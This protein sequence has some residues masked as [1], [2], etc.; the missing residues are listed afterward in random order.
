MIFINPLP[1]TY[2]FGRTLTPRSQKV[3]PPFL[4][5]LK[6]GLN[7]IFHLRTCCSKKLSV[8]GRAPPTKTMSQGGPRGGMC[9]PLYGGLKGA[10][11]PSHPSEI[12]GV[13]GCENG[14]KMTLKWRSSSYRDTMRPC[15]ILLPQ[16]QAKLKFR[17]KKTCQIA[18]FG[19]FE[20]TPCC[21][22]N[23]R[24]I[25]TCIFW[26]GTTQW[27]CMWSLVWIQ[28]FWRK[29]EHF[30]NRRR[31]DFKKSTKIRKTSMG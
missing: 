22:G 24:W 4:K 15:D 10:V 17:P 13:Q 3:P 31:R 5:L 12:L 20:T 27:L 8:L 19:I 2:A 29:L 30:E 7:G 23:G 11:A 21:Y 28:C 9:P 26:K 18:H 14:L 25:K 6:Y 16:W 1:H